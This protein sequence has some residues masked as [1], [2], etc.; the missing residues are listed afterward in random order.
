MVLRSSFSLPRLILSFL[1]LVGISLVFYNFSTIRSHVPVA[2]SPDT[3]ITGSDSGGK[4]VRPKKGGSLHGIDPL[5]EPEKGPQGKLWG[6]GETNRTSAT[7]LALVRNEELPGMLQSMKD[8][9]RTWNHKFLYP[10]TFFND[11]PFTEE[12]KRKTQE[13]TKAECRYG[14]LLSAEA[15]LLQALSADPS[16]SSSC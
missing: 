8:L 15:R 13:V 9:E 1:C 2:L 7:L 11:E 14:M 10:W 5:L 4:F 12:F 6:P 16:S 3:Y